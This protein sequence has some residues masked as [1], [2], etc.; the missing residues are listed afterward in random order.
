MPHRQRGDHRQRNGGRITEQIFVVLEL[1]QLVGERRD[2]LHLVVNHVD[3]FGEVRGLI[4]D[5]F[6]VHDGVVNDV[7]RVKGERPWQADSD[8]DDCF[9]HG[10]ISVWVG[11]IE[12]S[13]EIAWSVGKSR[14]Q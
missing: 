1:V 7:L 8:K 2:L 9:F 11:V 3:V 6:S 13:A 4:R 14:R 10:W 12:L 5:L